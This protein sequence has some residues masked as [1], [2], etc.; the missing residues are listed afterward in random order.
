M[1]RAKEFIR[2][3][4]N[5][6]SPASIVQITGRGAGKLGSDNEVRTPGPKLPND[7]LL[8]VS[9]ALFLHVLRPDPVRGLAQA[10]ARRTLHVKPE[11]LYGCGR[12][13][14]HTLCSV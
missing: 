13:A 2:G 11:R 9:R 8:F 10:A 14:H 5:P 4:D 12:T 7:K 6:T 3:I 1:A